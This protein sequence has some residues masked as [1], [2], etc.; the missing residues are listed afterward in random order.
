MG[1]QCQKVA[2]LMRGAHCSAG[3]ARDSYEMRSKSR[4]DAKKQRDVSHWLQYIAAMAAPMLW[5]S[6][7]LVK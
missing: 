2:G 6:K 1:I 4:N 3:L 7:R 5:R